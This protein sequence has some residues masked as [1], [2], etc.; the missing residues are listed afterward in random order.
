MNNKIEKLK[1]SKWSDK[2][3]CKLALLD[4]LCECLEKD[5]YLKATDAPKDS[6]EYKSLDKELM[7]LKIILDMYFDDKDK[8]YT[9]RINKFIDNL[10]K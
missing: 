3:L 9:E 10:E 1:K 8:L 6:V 7:D 2:Y 5:N 4:H